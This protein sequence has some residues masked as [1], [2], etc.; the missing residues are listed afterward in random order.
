MMIHELRMPDLTTNDAPIRIVRWIAQVGEDVRQGQPLLEVE[1]DKATMEVES[2]VAGRLDQ[3][4][5]PASQD[6]SVGQVIALVEVAG[7]MPAADGQAPARPETPAPVV[8]EV[9]PPAGPSRREPAPGPAGMFARQRAARARRPLEP[10]RLSLSV[11][12]RTMAR[13]M[14]SSKQA[15]PHFYLQT[16]FQAAQ[17]IARR[18]AAPPPGPV[19]DAFFVRAV[20]LALGR[21][22]RFRC[23]WE[24]ESLQPVNTDAVGVAVDLDDELF[25]IAIAAAA[26]KS[27]AQISQ[28][29]RD[30]VAR[31]RSGE[32]EARRLRPAWMTVTNLGSCDVE[33]FAPIINPPEPAILGV[34]KVAR[35]PAVQDDGRVVVQYRGTLTLCVDHRVA[36]G[37]YAA[38]FLGAIVEEL[39]K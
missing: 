21:F 10:D 20:A 11:A 7:P 29:I 23:R 6:A 19:W 37:K 2:A 14:Q 13:R 4:L 24:D 26:T 17:I 15:V 36:S 27:V 3:I 30:G 28:E 18:Q 9:V 38:R 16:T 34:G 1:T 25:V 32:Q 5:C 12:Q 39:E 35:T 33:R 8:P 22:E 31:L